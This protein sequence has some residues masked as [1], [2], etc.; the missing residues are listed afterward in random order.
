MADSS[1]YH[2]FSGSKTL[3]ALDPYPIL[4]GVCLSFSEDPVLSY[5]HF[6]RSFGPNQE[7]VGIMATARPIGVSLSA[8]VC[9]GVC[10]SIPAQYSYVPS[11]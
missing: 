1:V 11:T 5:C 4:K 6:F 2:P 8:P 7:A 9:I 3:Y 10:L